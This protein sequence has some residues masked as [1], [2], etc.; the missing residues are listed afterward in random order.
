MDIVAMPSGCSACA[1]MPRPTPAGTLS[2]GAGVLM[3]TLGPAHEIEARFVVSALPSL[4]GDD[5]NH[6]D[7]CRAW[8]RSR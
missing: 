3:V 1:V 6:D 8:Y 4:F 7:A 2:F 5:G